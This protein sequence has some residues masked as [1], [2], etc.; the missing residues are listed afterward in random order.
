MSIGF[1]VFR[2]FGVQ[3]WLL[4]CWVPAEGSGLN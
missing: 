4:G 2:G 1:K 3:S